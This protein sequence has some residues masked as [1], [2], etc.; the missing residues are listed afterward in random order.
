MTEQLRPSQLMQD[1]GVVQADDAILARPARPFELPDE[2]PAAEHTLD[3]LHEALDRIA[4]VHDFS[5]GMGLA[6]PQI[7]LPRAAAIVRPPTPGADPIILLNP[8]I[9]FASAETDEQYEGCLSFF[10]VRG[11]VPRSL[12]VTMQ[13]TGLDGCASRTGYD[14]ALARLI[15]H[16]VDHLNGVLYT[17]RMR[18]NL[19]PIPLTQYRGT[20]QAWVY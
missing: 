9:I 3:Q 4:T 20:G 7:G 18:P 11:L 1:L 16:E 2:R 10:D 17:Q 14:Y 19:T 5:K 6:A 15:A 13:H 8:R 12:R